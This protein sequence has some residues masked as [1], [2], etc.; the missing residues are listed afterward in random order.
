MW[1]LLLLFIVAIALALTCRFMSQ[2]HQL[3]PFDQGGYSGFYGQ[4]LFIKQSFFDMFLTLDAQNQLVS[5]DGEQ[6]LFA[7]TLVAKN[8][9]V[10]DRKDDAM[11]YLNDVFKI[12]HVRTGQWIR[13]DGAG[14]SGTAAVQE[15]ALFG[16]QNKYSSP[17]K[18]HVQEYDTTPE[19]NNVNL[20][21]VFTGTDARLR[22]GKRKL[23]VYANKK[24]VRVGQCDGSQ[25]GKL[26][27]KN[28]N[29]WKCYE[30]ELP[31]V[32]A[33]TTA[34]ADSGGGGKQQQVS[35][36]TTK[37][38]GGGDK[39]QQ[40]SSTTT[41]SG[42]GGG[43]GD[44]AGT[45]IKP[46]CPPTSNFV[47]D[48]NCFR[49]FHGIPPL[50]EDPE[51]VAASK[52]CNTASDP[53]NCLFEH[54]KNPYAET[55]SYQPGAVQA[56]YNEIVCYDPATR[57]P[58]QFDKSNPGKKCNYSCGGNC[59]KPDCTCYGHIQ[60]LM[61]TTAAGCHV[62]KDAKGHEMLRCQFK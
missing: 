43:G 31:G 23:L 8:K 52:G 46:N 22:C 36:T 51:L 40:V 59:G 58:L 50:K 9:R 12:K 11:I 42:G 18:P 54:S 26:V 14:F 38:G 62:C 17:C 5:I 35:S 33:A 29:N 45:A 27:Y 21:P 13:V 24:W 37:S 10:S 53:G 41:K 56:L 6:D 48:I 19:V 60:N 7:L 47:A 15:A 1:S 30:F 3:E 16:L 25:G 55:L 49:A 57:K 2:H 61:E 20:H 44:P 32:S 28:V 39:Q 34:G 4:P